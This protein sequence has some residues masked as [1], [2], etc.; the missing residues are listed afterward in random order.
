[1]YAVLL[2]IFAPTCWFRR[3]QK[4]DRYGVSANSEV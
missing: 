2:V 3:K 1:M 4:S